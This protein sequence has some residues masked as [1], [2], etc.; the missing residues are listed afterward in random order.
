MAVVPRAAGRKDST[1]QLWQ[2]LPLRDFNLGY[3]AFGVTSRPGR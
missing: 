3:V 1:P 2:E